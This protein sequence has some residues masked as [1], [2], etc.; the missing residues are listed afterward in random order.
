MSYRKLGIGLGVL[1]GVVLLVAVTPIGRDVLF[2]A[3]PLR[4][5]G[6]AERIASVLQ[7]GPGSTIA[8]VGAGSGALIEE[9]SRIAGPDG[10]AYATER[11]PTQR[12]AI[13]SRARAAG[14]NVSVIE[15]GDRATNLPDSCCDAVT[16]R[17]V[18]HHV[19]DAAAMAGDL[20]RAMK[21]GGRVGIIEFA[22]G[23]LPHLAD[24]H[25]IDPQPVVEAFA[26]AGFVTERTD[27]QWGG[28]T[29]LLVFRAPLSH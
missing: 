15:A 21:P 1:F 29:Y 5:T 26:S 16:V 13:A 23:A 11:T 27:M 18:M 10:W 22:P 3:V 12:E 17:M 6:E 19:T 14:L 25:G 20:R 28:R 2:H 7:I 8:D 4:W 9:L 24:D